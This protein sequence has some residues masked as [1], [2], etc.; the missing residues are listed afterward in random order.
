MT[1][2]LLTFSTSPRPLTLLCALVLIVAGDAF[3]Q[4]KSFNPDPTDAQ[5]CPEPAPQSFANHTFRRLGETIEIPIN[6]AD[7]Q[8]VALELHW[9]NGRNN[10]SNFTVTFLDTSERPIYT[11][12]I[13]AFMSGNV[14]F[15]FSTFYS[16]PYWGSQS[17]ISVPSMVTIQAVSPFAYPASL[18]YRVTRVARHLPPKPDAASKRGKGE[19]EDNANST[20]GKTNEKH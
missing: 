10:G 20:A 2:K 14:E 8:A 19:A 4:D 6:V 11:K 5:A 9:S 7:C 3:S 17:L 18:S 16:Q 12:Q 15:P 13:S 1:Q